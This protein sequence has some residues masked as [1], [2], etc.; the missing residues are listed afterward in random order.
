MKIMFKHISCSSLLKLFLS[1]ILLLM[2]VEVN[3]AN[4]T[5]GTANTN[6]TPTQIGGTNY[7]SSDNISF[8]TWNRTYNLTG[9]VTCANLNM[10][11]GT[12]VN[13]NGFTLTVTVNLTLSDNNVTINVGSGK[14]TIDGDLTMT[15]YYTNGLFTSASGVVELGGNL[16][17]N[18]NYDTMAGGTSGFK[19][20]LRFIGATAPTITLGNAPIAIATL[21][22][23]NLTPTTL[24]TTFATTNVINA[25]AAGY[26]T[27]SVSNNTR[28][29]DR[30]RIGSIDNILSGTGF[31]TGG[32]ADYT[33]LITDLE[34]GQTSVP[35]TLDVFSNTAYGLNVWVDWDQD[36]EF[37]QINDNVVCYYGLS[38]NGNNQ[39]S[40]T[41][42]VPATA[43]LGNTRLR[44][45]LIYNDNS[46]NN[47]CANF[48]YGEVEDYTV[49]VI[50]PTS[51]TLATSGSRCGSGAVVLNA[52]ASGTINWYAS[53]TGGS[54]LKTGNSFTT[55]S[56]STTTVYYVD[57]TSGSFTSS[58]RVAVTASII[59]PP[60]ISASGGGSYCTGSTVNLTST[61]TGITNQ[62]WTGPNSF[63]SL[64]QNPSIGGATAAMSGTY[65]VI[66]SA[67]SGTNLVSNGDFEAGNTGF[68]SAYLNSSD[69][70]PEGTY[71]VVANPNS[72]HSGYTNCVDHTPA[73]TLQMVVNGA[74]TGG[75]NVWSQSVNVVA[76][77]DYQ[78][79]Y[80][81]QSVVDSNPSQLQLYVN[82]LPAGPTYTANTA[83]CSWKKFMYNWNS[84]SSTTA[85]LSL[86]NKNL[87]TGGNDFALDDIVFEQACTASATV[88]VAVAS[89]FIPAVSISATSNSICEGTSVTFTATPTNGGA[90]PSYQWK[91]GSTNVG[92]N[93]PTYTTSSL[94]RGDKVTCVLTSSLLCASPKTAT[95][96]L[97]PMTVST[98][99]TWSNYSLPSPTSICLGGAVTFNVSVTGG[100][101]GTISWI[102]SSSSGG[103][104]TI[105]T[106]GDT[107]ALGTWYYRPHY[108]PTGTG[109]T[110]AEGTETAV[111][112]NN[113]PAAVTVSGGGTFC[114]NTTITA[115]GGSGGTIYF[116]GTTSGGTSATTASSSQVVSSSGTYYFR[117]RSASGCWGTQGSVTV[118]VNQTPTAPTT[119]G[120]FICIGSTATLSASGAVSGD[121]YLWYSAATGG[122]LLQTSTNNTYTTPVL[123]ATTNY[124]VSILSAGGCESP[125][126]IV[127]ATYP[128]VSTDAQTPGTD[129]WIGYMY[130]GINFATYYGHFTEPETFYEGFGGNTT[131]FGIVSNSISRSIYT[132]TFSVKYLMNS[133]KK[134]LWAV[135]L[136]SDDG[137]RLTVNG[138]VIYDDW[139]NHGVNNNLGVLMN[140]NG[141]SS[142]IYEFYE[143]GG[144]N[145]VYFQNLIQILANELSTNITQTICTGSSGT[146][147]SGDVFPTIPG[148]AYVGLSNPG[149]QWSYSTTSSSG[150]WT[151]ISGETAATYTPSFT[152]APFNTAT[153]YYFIRKASVQSANNTG[154]ANYVATNESNAATITVL[155]LPEI[156]TQ[157][158]D[159]SLCENGTGSVSI[160]TSSVLD[161]YQWE[162]S[163]DNA[164]WYKTDGI[165]G[166]SGHTENK[167]IITNPPLIYSGNYLRCVV[168][169]GGCP[170]Y[171][172]SILVTVNAKPTTPNATLT[173][174]T[175]GVS[176]G[177]ITV[178][179]PVAAGMSYSINGSDYTNTTGIFSGVAPNTYTITAK[180]SN[181]CISSGKS[182]TI[183][184]QPAMSNAP[185]ITSLQLCSGTN[186]ISGTSVSGAAITIYAGTTI[187]GTGTASG[188]SWSVTVSQAFVSGNVITAKATATG[189]CISAVSGSITV[190]GTPTAPTVGLRTQPTCDDATGSV[191]LNGLPTGNWTLTQ[192]PGGTK[193]NGSGT[194]KTISGLSTGTYNYTVTS[195]D[196]S[197]AYP[198]SGTGL[199]TEYFNNMTLAGVPA[200]TRTDATVN[201]D[202]GSGDPGIP[203]G[204]DYFSVQWTGQVQPRYSEN[205]TFTTISD[206]GI[207]LWVNGSQII[208]NWGDHGI[209]TDNSVPI[210]LIAGQKYDIKL[211]FYENGGE[212]VAKL[213][214]SSASQTQQ[215]I[216]QTQLY[217]EVTGCTSPASA[218]VII[219]VVPTVPATPTASVTVQPT[220][221]VPTGT[222]VI[223][224]PTGSTLEYQ[225][226][227]GVFQ[228]IATFTGVTIGN[229]TVKARLAAS[230]TCISSASSTLTVKA[231]PSA[232]TT[233]TAS[234]TV[235]PTC[236]VTSGTIVISAPTGAQY[237]YQLDGGTYQASVTFTDVSVGN[238]TVKARL[239]T[240]Q[241]CI[242]SASSTLTVNAVPANPTAII[243]GNATF[244]EATSTD[245]TVSLTGTSPWSITYSDGSNST[246]VN[247]INTNPYTITV[248]PTVTTTYTL[249]SVSDANCSGT[250]TGS[251][252]ITIPGEILYTPSN[253]LSICK[254]ETTTL[255][256]TP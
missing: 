179:S 227:G 59:T 169:S 90:T 56:L 195:E 78:F 50:S 19:G 122:T 192:F 148:T 247:G 34:V 170:V 120:A 144:G 174:P 21:D 143:N 145:V 76:G 241:T 115:S 81:V 51:I 49:N 135:D 141:S 194:N 244:C 139:S 197:T 245:L 79:T 1:I 32:Y 31:T 38:N 99:P 10:S 47:P 110:L 181:G 175:C 100:L 65:T 17:A 111:T 29:I 134:G 25:G 5:A 77:T 89:S 3:A 94:T 15:N 82:N 44:V 4:I 86:V 80:W 237:E 209:T 216:P 23:N 136:G 70:T 109:C 159:L 117:S 138:S 66:G 83:I 246:T 254:G 97:V 95:S 14:L 168:S 250:G 205:Y 6:W 229:H 30:V 35:I 106:T 223:S 103:V 96:N 113:L 8:S 150:P 242:S 52:T 27:P 204:N 88:D 190:N 167:L 58:P 187:I 128:S 26:C 230:P 235:Q 105:V 142:L 160:A 124:W 214:W 222:I 183:N 249:I 211:E 173:Q 152:A 252:S 147:I 164:T 16:T 162:Y 43:A 196:L 98:Q 149:Y 221:A 91:R 41:F 215:F 72:V 213:Y 2:F 156:T 92:T 20:T 75:V 28:Y 61:G 84:G 57:A 119:T 155:A 224:A 108:A 210:T 238:H 112:V 146:P 251:A 172:N 256:V 236:A 176:T 178:T 74:L 255:S 42:N 126:T 185:V 133:T 177:T 157:P 62:Y 189:K 87:E 165:A 158:S 9:N 39:R 225:L 63:Y 232:P 240:S 228:T 107:P 154:E 203:I 114:G 55:P 131:C 104:G 118:T 69:L 218:N 40:Y 163:T 206:D 125:R 132:E 253:D 18:N 127:T 233:P 121:Q 140:L 217:S 182:V 13:L 171:S 116:Q 202:W 226:D 68:G 45:R 130:D 48:Y 243:S 46:C 11:R 239:T 33:S 161:T 166:V 198:G 208:N 207:R 180:N 212:A 219:N 71:A 184:A 36:G 199:Y 54:S 129:S 101:G 191:F 64:S 24:P 248:S 93:S 7:A 186:S 85:L 37:T 137:N 201:F 200:L 22:W 73:G 60:T 231:V 12:I 123:G 220:C 153:T 193:I 67:L 188:T 151:D 102:R 234:G 53:S